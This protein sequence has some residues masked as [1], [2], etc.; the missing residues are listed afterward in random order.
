MNLV[1][2]GPRVERVGRAAEVRA[3]GGPFEGAALLESAD[4]AEYH[5]GAVAAVV[6]DDPG[7]AA[8]P[9]PVAV[10]E[11]LHLVRLELEA[12]R[13]AL[14]R[15]GVAAVVA[16]GLDGA[17]VRAVDAKLKPAGHPL[18]LPPSGRRGDLQE[19]EVEVLVLP[20]HPSGRDEDLVNDPGA[21]GPPAGAIPGDELDVLGLRAGVEDAGGG[22]EGH[23]LGGAVDDPARAE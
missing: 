15:P 17:P 22:R 4:D 10:A 6:A 5:A 21:E 12:V 3:V 2:L 18:D 14:N 23:V 9:V 8:G 1:P 19:C 13:R 20:V 11:E 7:A 16:D